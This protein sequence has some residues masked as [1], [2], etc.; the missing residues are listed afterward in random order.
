[1][2]DT[3][4]IAVI[5]S[6]ITANYLCDL[7]SIK[8]YLMFRQRRKNDVFLNEIEIQRVN[9]I[10]KAKRVSHGTM[11]VNTVYKYAQ[12][13]PLEFYIYDVFDENDESSGIVLVEALRM[14]L[15]TEIDIIVMSLTCSRTYEDDFNKL[16]EKIKEKNV[17]LIC[18][19]ANDGIMK[20]PA[21]L[22][23]VYGVTGDKVNVCG[24][25]RYDVN[26]ELQFW[27]DIQG[28]FVGE[29][30]K[31]SFFCGTSK[32]TAVVAGRLANYMFKNGKEA[33]IDYLAI[34]HDE[35]DDSI[36][37]SESNSVNEELLVEFCKTFK[38]S[39]NVCIE[40]MDV[41]IPWN[42]NNIRSFEMFMTKIGLKN[43]IITLN[44]SEFATVHKIMKSCERRIND[45]SMDAV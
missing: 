44:Y 29:P 14:I 5:D 41:L 7:I 38:L 37:K 36:I 3:I 10:K 1:M 30:G 4:K 16:K 2:H 42:V 23:F 35:F 15:E 25:Y 24:K 33:L 34:N 11:V 13:V 45:V 43:E 31:Y 39:E 27:S 9:N 32:A 26:E 8:D 28:E 21:N 6:N 17:V 19:A 40:N 12:N 22:E 18:S 20:F